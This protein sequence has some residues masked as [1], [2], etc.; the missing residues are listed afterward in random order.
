MTLIE[1]VIAQVKAYVPTLSGNVSGAADLAVAIES[2]SSLPLPAAFVVPVEYD[3]T[4]N[5][6]WPGLQQ[7]VTER[8]A[9]VV[10]FDNTTG[11]DA[12]ARTGFTGADQVYPMRVAL[13]SALLS[14]LPPNLNASRGFS[15]GAG[16]MILSNRAHMLWQFE[17]T[18]D[19]TITDADGF[20]PYGDRLTDALLTLQPEGDPGP[21][22]PII[23]DIPVT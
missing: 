23:V 9:V 17:F 20:G 10:E 19:V 13:F 2:V 4:D 16:R 7:I 5:D 22:I 14:W 6:L 18:I 12:D 11:S 3:P 1:T 15:S 8:I 21:A